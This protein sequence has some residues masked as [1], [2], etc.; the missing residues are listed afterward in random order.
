MK[1]WTA[2]RFDRGISEQLQ[3][4]SDKL[5]IHND[6]L[7]SHLGRVNLR[8]LDMHV[9]VLKI[10]LWYIDLN[11]LKLKLNAEKVLGDFTGRDYFCADVLSYSPA[12][13]VKTH[14]FL[15]HKNVL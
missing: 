8:M 7:I 3:N 1:V 13:V 11:G 4:Q 6:I 14:T 9:F 15:T 5:Q 12:K 2:S 10:I